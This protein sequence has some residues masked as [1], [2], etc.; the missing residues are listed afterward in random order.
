[1]KVLLTGASGVLGSAFCEHG[2]RAWSWTHR[3]RAQLDITDATAVFTCVDEVAPDVIINC[4]AYTQV[5][6]AEAEPEQ[7]HAVNVLGP[8][9]LAKAAKRHDAKLVHVSTDYVFDGERRT[10]YDEQCAPRPLSVYG[11]TKRAGELKVQD[12]GAA[13]LIVRTAWL[14]GDTG[15]G[16]P[17]LMMRLAKR[18]GVRVV[19]DQVGSPTYAPHLVEGI[20]ESLHADALGLL[21]L[22]GEGVVTRYGLAEAL[23]ESLNQQVSLEKAS[24]SDFPAP[25]TRP[26]FSG[27]CS[28]HACGVK[29]PHWKEG[30]LQFA[31]LKNHER[32]V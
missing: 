6:R 15:P 31:S 21:H 4:A 3:T 32:S 12:S 29:L 28:N 7:A 16:F 9:L 22:A 24:T 27:L 5:D 2:P 10:P 18:G 19:T 17:A 11:Q 14:Y 1:M 13:H 20:V 23:F 25:A 8:E 26:A 30:V